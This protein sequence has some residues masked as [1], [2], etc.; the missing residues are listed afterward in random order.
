GELCEERACCAHRAEG[1]ASQAQESEAAL[2]FQ[3]RQTTDQIRQAEANLAAAQAQQAAAEAD[4]ENARL[5]YER[6]Q[7]MTSR[8][9]APQEQFDQARTA[10]DAAR[11]RVASLTRQVDAQRSAV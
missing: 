3:E 5:N 7:K 10:Y 6:Q 4:L 2:R 11:A 1:A 8:G 9:I